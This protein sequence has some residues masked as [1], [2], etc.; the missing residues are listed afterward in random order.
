MIPPP[1]RTPPVK[2]HVAR[3]LA[4]ALAGVLL[5]G[6]DS[7]LKAIDKKTMALLEE[8]TRQINADGAPTYWS[9]ALTEGRALPPV[10]PDPGQVSTVNPGASELSFTARPE[11]EDVAARIQGL[12]ASDDVMEFDLAGAVRYAM[13]NGP[14]YKNAADN[15]VLDAMSLLIEEHRWGP[16]FFDDVSAV[17]SAVGDKGLYRSSLS[18]VNQFTVEQRLPYGGTVSASLLAAATQNLHNLVAAENV[19]DATAIISADIPL[20]RGAGLAARE[21]LIQAQRNVVYAARDFETFR[22]QFFFDITTDYLDLVVRKQN[23]ENARRQVEGFERT[24]RRE[25][26]LVEAGRQPSFQAALAAQDTLFARDRL[27][28]QLEQY[29]LALDRFKVRIGMPVENSIDVLEEM[30]SVAVPEVEAGRSVMT[31]L[32]LRLDVQTARDRV[33]D[34]KRQ[35]DVAKNRTLPDLNVFGDISVPTN[36]NIQRSGLQLRPDYG[37]Y[38]GGVRLSLPLDRVIEET[39]LRQTQVQYEQTLRDYVQFRDQV[40]VEIRTAARGIDRAIFSIQIQQENVRVAELR[41][42]SID[43]APDRADARARSD[44]VQGLL[45]ARDSLDRAR[46]DLQV[47]VLGYLLSTGQLRVTPSGEMEMIPGMQSAKAS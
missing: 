11:A 20:L 28:T 32:T 19:Q 37:N 43:A 39:Q 10:H 29:R 7:G 9:N 35:I 17:A 12:G 46:R 4:A 3:L 16:R 15:Y 2:G 30:P 24:E 45:E 23:I 44:A 22:R 6:C 25:L 21:D 31:G 40:A 27:A 34:R 5:T 1:L 18:L 42:A 36:P 38:S 41:Q 13:E 26:A 14:E 33:E 47:A 8:T